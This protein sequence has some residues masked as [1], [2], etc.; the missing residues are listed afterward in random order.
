MPFC[1]SMSQMAEDVATIPSSPWSAAVVVEA[2]VPGIFS[3]PERRLLYGRCRLYDCREVGR[4]EARP[5][6]QRA[7][8]LR[9][10]EEF[11]GVLRRHRAAILDAE[12]IGRVRTP[13][14]RDDRA[15]GAD[16]AVGG[17]G[18]RGAS[19]ADCPDRLVG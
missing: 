14:A 6:D 17:R 8:D 5:A 2:G 9:P 16:H 12:R 1:P 4:L 11:G 10:G 3:L 7:I 18:G 13:D 19:G 15:D